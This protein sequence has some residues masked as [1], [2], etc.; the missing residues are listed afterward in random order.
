MDNANIILSTDIVGF[1]ILSVLTLIPLVTMVLVIITSQPG[2]ALRLGIGGAI[3]TLLLSLYM[4]NTF[5]PAQ[6]VGVQFY[7]KYQLSGLTYSVGVDGTS[8]LFV[9]VTAVL[10]VLAMIYTLTTRR[11]SD[12]IHIACMLGYQGILIGAFTAMNA[13]QFWFWCFL[14][15]IPVVLMTLRAGSGQNRRWVVALLLQHWGSGLFMVLAGFLMLG[16]GIMVTTDVLSFDW[17][18][19]K[20]N[21]VKLEYATLIFFL[22]FF[23]FAIRMPLFPFHGW[24]PVLAE[25]GTVASASIFLV[26]LKLGI[27]GAMRFLIPLLPEVAEQWT[28]FVTTLGLIGIFY[29]ALLAL[30]QINIRRLLAFAIISQTGLLVIGLFDFNKYGME[31]SILLSVQTV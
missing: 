26:S 29:G 7:E 17:L 15:L 12:K 8:I 14:E 21:D 24:L 23:G 27:Y 13:M 16:F 18:V 4:L 28:W 5:D 20:E 19:L 25:Q 6:V 1:P 22:L 30:M 9:V 11:V 10:A 3:L 2:V 31:G